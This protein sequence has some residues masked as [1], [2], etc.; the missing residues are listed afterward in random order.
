MIDPR[1]T[2]EAPDDD[3]YLWLEEIDG[4]G[5]LAWVDAQNAATLARFGDRRFEAD[6]NT[7]AEIYDRPDNIPLIAR[8]GAKVFNFWKDAEHPRGLWRATSLDSFRGER[9]DWEILFDLD[10]VAATEAEDWTGSGAATIPGSH[11][12]AILMLSR[13]GADAVVLREFDLAE[14]DF[15]TSGFALPEA[16]GGAAWLDRDTLLLSSALG[17]DMATGSGYARTV[18]LWRR[19]GDPLTAPVIFRTSADPMA[20]LAGV[21]RPAEGGGPGLVVGGACFHRTPF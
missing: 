6:R 11:D 19:G 3:P 10:A 15:V 5:A 12:R 18:R 17:E 2:V 13:G 7:L 14:R 16:K 9:P 21:G 8:R 20:V 1:P 4:K